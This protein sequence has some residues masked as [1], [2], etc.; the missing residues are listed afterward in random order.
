MPGEKYYS[1]YAPQ[2]FTLF[3]DAH[4][5]AYPDGQAF[6]SPGELDL[7]NVDEPL[8]ELV[9]KINSSGCIST[10]MCCSGHPERD[11][12]CVHHVELWLRVHHGDGLKSLM[13]WLELANRRRL[14]LGGYAKERVIRLEYLGATVNGYYFVVYGD[15]INVTENAR[16]CQALTEAW[17]L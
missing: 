4:T 12:Y 8:Q 17:Q 11:E 6:A 1:H 15:F 3:W 14:S 13:D 2:P 7:A 10:V 9:G 16:I 5:Q